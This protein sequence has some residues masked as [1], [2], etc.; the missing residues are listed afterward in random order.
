MTAARSRP[1]RKERIG[2]AA[3]GRAV[4][5]HAARPAW[6]WRRISRT[7]CRRTASP[8]TAS[9][10]TGRRWCLSPLQVEAYF[11][12][13]EKALDLCIVDEQREA[14]DS[15]LSHG[16]GAA[17]N[18]Q[19]C[20]D[21]LVLGAISELLEQRRFRGDRAEAGQAVRVSSRF[22]C[23]PT[24]TSSKATPATTRSAAGG[25]S[26]ASTTRLRLRARHARAIPRAKPTRSCPSGLLLRPAIPSPEIF[27]Q[28][29]TYGPMANFKISLRE[30]PDA[31]ELSRHGQS[32]A[33]RRRVCCSMPAR[34]PQDA[35]GRRSIVVP[36]WP[37]SPD[38]TRRRSREAGIYQVD[39][40]LRARETRRG[41]CR[42]SWASGSLPGSSRAQAGRLRRERLPSSRRRSCSSGCRR[43][44]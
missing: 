42:W 4:S 35:G 41:C 13:A 3:D 21:N 29:N 1:A 38:A 31:G 44:S 14:G 43:V 9:P 36:I 25:S 12:I 27:G 24:T 40:V 28:S 2:A 5:E 11:D 10:T 34:Q 7:C 6:G 22:A 32:R 23:G 39:V 18:P 17:I 30:L 33:L 16:S 8:R 15:E 37:A 19:P 26:T 20:P